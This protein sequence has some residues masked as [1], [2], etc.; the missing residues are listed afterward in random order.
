MVDNIKVVSEEQFKSLLE[1][2]VIKASMSFNLYLDIEDSLEANR[3]LVNDGWD[4][5]Y[6]RSPEELHI[7]WWFHVGFLAFKCGSDIVVEIGVGNFFG[8]T[9]RSKN[10]GPIMLTTGKAL[11]KYGV[12]TLVFEKLL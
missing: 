10:Y 11:K 2:K 7:Y 8:V 5:Y 1:K 4:I 6:G 12:S 3:T 9:L